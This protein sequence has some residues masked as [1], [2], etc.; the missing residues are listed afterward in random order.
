MTCFRRITNTKHSQAE[1]LGFF[2]FCD[3]RQLSVIIQDKM[4][5]TKDTL[6]LFDVD[7]TLTTARQE[8]KPEMKSFLLKKLKNKVA[9]GLVSGSDL[10]KVSEQ[11][12]KECVQDFDFVF[13]EN[14]LV[15]YKDGNLVGKESIANFMGEEKLQKFINF[16]L[17]YMSD[18]HLPVK[19]GTFIEFRNGL[20]NIC[21]PGRSVTQEQR[22]QFGTLDNEKKYRQAFVDALNKEFPDIGLQFAIGGQISID[23][24][25]HG[26][27]KRYCL[28][29]VEKDFKEI[30]FFGDRTTEGG[31]DYLIYKDH[32][33]IGHAVKDPQDTMKKLA[34][35]F[36]L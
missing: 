35:T 1:L 15:A 22:D 31:N 21:P 16:C 10:S 2:S 23:A 29:F 17:R 6:V 5:S 20:I 13:P 33:T 34:E 12:G 25:P 19:R 28:R 14:G 30:H 32:R 7:G 9:I 24:Y 8:V 36:K 11:M 27:D 4:A 3:L 18:L 26:W